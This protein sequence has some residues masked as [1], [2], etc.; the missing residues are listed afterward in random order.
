MDVI[1]PK[2]SD[3]VGAVSNKDR[4]PEDTS[5]FENKFWLL[6]YHEMFNTKNL[7]CFTARIIANLN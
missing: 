6:F 3:W 7:N 5:P 2:V 4:A 1:Y